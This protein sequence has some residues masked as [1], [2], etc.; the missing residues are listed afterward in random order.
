MKLLSDEVYICA[1]C[2]ANHHDGKAMADSTVIW[3]DNVK[4][5]T[6]EHFYSSN[7]CRCCDS[8]LGGYRFRMAIWDI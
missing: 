1:D 7:A 5:D 3:T 6:E 2:Y 8:K 4:D